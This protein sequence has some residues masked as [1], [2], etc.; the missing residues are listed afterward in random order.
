[1]YNLHESLLRDR[2]RLPRAYPQT[3][4]MAQDSVY[5]HVAGAEFNEG[6]GLVTRTR[7]GHVLPSYDKGHITGW[8]ALSGLALVWICVGL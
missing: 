1:M 2:A 7:K 3:R 8:F 5:A 6:E 4:I